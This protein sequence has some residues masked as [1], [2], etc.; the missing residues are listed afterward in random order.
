[1]KNCNFDEETYVEARKIE[2]KRKFNQFQTMKQTL[3]IEY[4]SGDSELMLFCARLS[5]TIVDWILLEKIMTDPEFEL[6]EIDQA[7]RLQLCYNVFPGGD[8]VFHCL[9][10]KPRIFQLSLT[11]RLQL[12]GKKDQ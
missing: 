2:D 3:A 8:S 10:A 7:Q 5:F 11:E 9:A 6:D 1:M 12:E 4:H